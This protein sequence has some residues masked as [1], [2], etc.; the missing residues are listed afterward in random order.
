MMLKLV[1]AG[2]L[3]ALALTSS[4]ARADH[5]P[6]VDLGRVVD[7]IDRLG[8][9]FSGDSR[10]PEGRREGRRDGRG[11]GRAWVEGHYENRETKRVVPA[12][13]RQ[14]WV[15]DR[16]EEVCIPAVT[17]RVCVPAVTERVWCPPIVERVRV[18][19]VREN[20]FIPGHYETR[21]D[22]RG[23]SCQVWVASHYENRV[24]RPGHYEE[25]VVRP[26]RYETRVVKPECWE[27]RVVTPERR[28]IRVVE[29]GHLVTV[30]V[31]P[32]RCEVVTERVWVP[33]HWSNDPRC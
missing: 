10:R 8:D 23:C 30:V 6:D 20:R 16:T 31:R 21:V 5:G 1:T 2:T 12:V 11:D 7:F 25:R 18:P 29:R 27:T 22:G 24:L 4:V 9:L 17:E 14:D 26:G 15:P 28:E 32:E 33:G 3:S 19:E 13:T